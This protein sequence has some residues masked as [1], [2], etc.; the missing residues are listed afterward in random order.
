MY[1]YY[2]LYYIY[3]HKQRQTRRKYLHKIQFKLWLAY[4]YIGLTL[5]DTLL[6]AMQ[7]ASNLLCQ[8]AIETY[9]SP[10]HWCLQTNLLLT[11]IIGWWPLLVIV[12]WCRRSR[13]ELYG[14]LV[15]VPKSPV[16]SRLYW[17]RCLVQS[18]SNNTCLSLDIVK[19]RLD[20]HLPTDLPSVC[21]HAGGFIHKH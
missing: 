2:K 14:T 1:M 20:Q 8:Q 6:S 5:L 11:L 10:F 18:R 7:Q 3:K 17:Q 4:K 12:G 13:P 19:D 9:I 21:D 15:A 16:D